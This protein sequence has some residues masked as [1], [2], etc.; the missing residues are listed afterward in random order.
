MFLECGFALGDA[1]DVKPVV[2]PLLA[3]GKLVDFSAQFFKEVKFTKSDGVV[4]SS[5]EE[6]NVDPDFDGILT[7]IAVTLRQG[8]RPSKE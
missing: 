6:M 1:G 5:F 8:V 7:E 3:L 2:D 4:V